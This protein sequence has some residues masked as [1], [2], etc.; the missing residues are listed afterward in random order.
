M[1][2]MGND[3]QFDDL[4]AF[5]DAADSDNPDK[6]RQAAKNLAEQGANGDK[7]PTPQPTLPN[8][9]T[10]GKER[11]DG[12][13]PDDPG[14]SDADLLL[15]TNEK[16]GE[17]KFIAID[18]ASIPG[19]EHTAEPFVLIPANIHSYIPIWGWITIA[20]V[21]VMMI[22]GVVLTPIVRL[23]RT[24]A[25]LGDGNQTTVQN[26]MRQL[27][28]KGDKKTVEKLYGIAAAPQEKLVVRLRAVDTMALIEKVPEVD[29]FLLR[30]EL[31]TETDEQIREAAI[32]ARKQ[33]EA[34]RTR[35]RP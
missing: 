16:G 14:I 19:S 2:Q 5:F 31:A 8:A 7:S 24:V 20:V 4:D 15:L 9:G 33:R 3:P 21:L 26:T 6:I 32:A 25:K 11:L 35:S 12:D 28:V 10:T 18:P 13:A 29:R 17:G 27:V 23:D 1:A 30:L 22:A 34:Y